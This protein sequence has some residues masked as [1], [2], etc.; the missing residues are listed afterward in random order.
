MKRFWVLLVLAALFLTACASV[1]YENFP[2]APKI[3]GPTEPW[4]ATVPLPTDEEGN[5]VELT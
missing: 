1:D 5:L 2:T 4:E 3:P